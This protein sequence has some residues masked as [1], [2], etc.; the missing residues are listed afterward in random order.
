MYPKITAN[1]WPEDENLPQPTIIPAWGQYVFEGDRFAVVNYDLTAEDRGTKLWETNAIF[2]IRP[3]D[4]EGAMGALLKLLNW[5]VYPT[6]KEITRLDRMR[7]WWWWHVDNIGPRN[8]RNLAGAGDGTMDTNNDDVPLNTSE[9]PNIYSPNP[10][11]ELKQ[12]ACKWSGDLVKVVDELQQGGT[13]FAIIEMADYYNPPIKYDGRW[14]YEGMI[15]HWWSDS[16]L[17]SCRTN[18]RLNGPITD[19]TPYGVVTVNDGGATGGK[20]F[21]R[22][23]TPTHNGLGALEMRNIKFYPPLPFTVLMNSQSYVVDGIYTARSGG[24]EVTVDQMCL[25]MSDTYFHEQDTNNWFRA[26][27]ML[28]ASQPTPGSVF[29]YRC[30]ASWDGKTP[31]MGRNCRTPICNW[32]REWYWPDG[33]LHGQYPELP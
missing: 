15:R 17:Y 24:R 30:Y 2:P 4:P 6:G 28:Q 5:R 23:V 1:P 9:Y 32:T 19:L 8:A 31:Y 25:H 11:K 16:W 7:S 3:V 20:G 29:G 14:Y 22:I 33:P 13:K 26:E 21:E 27:T 18:R 12:M 10:E